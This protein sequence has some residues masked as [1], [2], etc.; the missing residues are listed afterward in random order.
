M[1]HLKW[2]CLTDKIEYQVWNKFCNR[3]PQHF[4]VD[5]WILETVD[6]AAIRIFP[7]TKWGIGS[8]GAF[9]RRAAAR[10]CAWWGCW[11]LQHWLLSCFASIFFFIVS[12]VNIFVRC[13]LLFSFLLLSLLFSCHCLCILTLLWSACFAFGF[14]LRLWLPFGL[15]CR[16]LHYGLAI[17]TGCFFF[18]CWLCWLSSWFLSLS[19]SFWGWLITLLVRKRIN[20]KEILDKNIGQTPKARVSAAKLLWTINITRNLWSYMPSN[21][22]HGLIETLKLWNCLHMLSRYQ[23]IYSRNSLYF[24]PQSAIKHAVSKSESENKNWM[25]CF[26]WFNARCCSCCCRPMGT[27]YFV[28]YNK[29]WH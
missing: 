9:H 5:S 2:T 8:T 1:C 15:C 27:Q 6:S 21:L 4:F 12:W 20:I 25:H 23:Q 13:F 18:F 7:N 17:L 16:F 28:C 3:H 24:V 29:T 22:K 10:D 11:A 26:E 14:R 19:S